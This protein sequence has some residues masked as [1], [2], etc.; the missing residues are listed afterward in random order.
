[1][2]HVVGEIT[3]GAICAALFKRSRTGDGT[4]RN[5]IHDHGRLVLKEHLGAATFD[6]PLGPPAPCASSM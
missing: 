3:A 5:P 6:P 4:A 2:D 1:V